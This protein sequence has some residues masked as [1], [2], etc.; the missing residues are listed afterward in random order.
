MNLGKLLITINNTL[1]FA[2]HHIFLQK[3][4]LDFRLS[5][6][7]L[8]KETKEKQFLQHSFTN[9]LSWLS[10]MNARLWQV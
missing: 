3:T 7:L 5:I 1:V 8:V 10:T 6:F 9:R 2:S 4:L